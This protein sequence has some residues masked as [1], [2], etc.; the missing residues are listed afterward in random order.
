M[1]GDKEMTKDYRGVY[2][3]SCKIKD[4]RFE[5]DLYTKILT[6]AYTVHCTVQT[7]RLDSVLR[8]P[9]KLLQQFLVGYVKS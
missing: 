8:V 5:A 1:T 7:Y 3:L 2:R 4:E 6:H 9:G